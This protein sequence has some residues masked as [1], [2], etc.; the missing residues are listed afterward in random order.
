MTPVRVVSGHVYRL[1]LGPDGRR[2]VYRDGRLVAWDPKP[3]LPFAN[4]VPS[5]SPVPRRWPWLLGGFLLG[6]WL[7]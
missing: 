7:R 2:R 1:E 4:V 6:R 5:R 3:L